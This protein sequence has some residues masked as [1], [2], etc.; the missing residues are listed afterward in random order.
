MQK[1]MSVDF[2]TVYKKQIFAVLGAALLLGSAWLL[3]YKLGH[4][5]FQDYDEATYA[6]V[7]SESLAH[8]NFLSFTLINSPYFKKPPLLFW[9]IDVSREIIPN[10]EVAT[11]LPGALSAFALIIVVALLCFEVTGSV[12]AALLG[13]SILAT[14]GTFIEFARQVRFDILV[15]FFI[16]ATFYAWIKATKNPKWYIAAGIFFGL[17]FLSKDVIS[18]FAGVAVLSYAFAQRDF[19]FL[20]DKYFWRGFVLSLVIILPWHV[21]ETIKFGAAF[22]QTYLGAEVLTRVQA[23]IFG[24]GYGPTN[25]DY[26]WFFFN[27]AAP[28]AQLFFVS[29]ITP[30]LFFK[31]ISKP[32]RSTLVSCLVTIFV[33]GCVL[34]FSH[35]KAIS[36]LLPLYPFI[37]IVIAV[38]ASELWKL[39][40]K[41]VRSIVLGIFIVLLP[42]AITVAINEGFD[43]KEYYVHQVEYAHEEKAVGDLIGQSGPNPMVFEY[44]DNDLGTIEYYSKLPFTENEYMYELNDASV[45]APD[46]LVF[47]PDTEVEISSQFPQFKFTQLY[48][49]ADVS[50]FGVSR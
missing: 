50:L 17:A 11:R 29:L 4:E 2:F 43:V 37:A 41:D 22:W 21:Y 8:G 49:G 1:R 3:F 28:W 19:S 26:D 14:T 10:Q 27:F 32:V 34:A 39:G 16:L 12:G 45:I 6:E 35:T 44:K 40:G 47:T 33:I 18:A 5:A 48:A 31:K 7:T 13:A 42:Y 9:L 30:I 15:S 46:S 23:N 25:T 24:N 20:K 36:Y 38:S